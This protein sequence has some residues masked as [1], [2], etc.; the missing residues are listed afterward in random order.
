MSKNR[1]KK[2]LP[3][4]DDKPGNF[5]TTL[6]T[7]DQLPDDMKSIVMTE[8]G[9]LTQ[10]FEGLTQEALKIQK[11]QNVEEDPV[12]ALF[13]PLMLEIAFHKIQLGAVS[14]AISDFINKDSDPNENI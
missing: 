1:I 11:D 2:N 10:S 14:S 8:A 9:R 4:D 7:F 12:G 5:L 3:D 13:Y 6:Q